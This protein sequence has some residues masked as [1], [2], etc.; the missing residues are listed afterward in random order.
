L[1]AGALE[2]GKITVNDIIIDANFRYLGH[3]MAALATLTALADA[4][5]NDLVRTLIEGKQVVVLPEVAALLNQTSSNTTAWCNEFDAYLNSLPAKTVAVVAPLGNEGVDLTELHV[6]QQTIVW[7]AE[8]PIV[9][10]NQIASMTIPVSG[11]YVAINGTNITRGN[12]YGNYDE[13]GTITWFVAPAAINETL[14]HFKL[15]ITIDGNTYTLNVTFEGAPL[16]VATGTIMFPKGTYGYVAIPVTAEYSNSVINVTFGGT[17]GTSIAAAYAAAAVALQLAD[18]N[19]VNFEALLNNLYSA[20][21][22][23]ES[24]YTGWG[25]ISMDRIWFS[26]VKRDAPLLSFPFDMPV[27][28]ITFPPALPA[29]GGSGTVAS[30]TTPSS[31]NAVSTTTTAI[32]TRTPVLQVK[33]PAPLAIALLPASLLRRVRRKRQKQ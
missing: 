18:P 15:N 7:P 21:P 14:N 25:A 1:I 22:G 17:E 9:L 33:V 12:V 24:P 2:S 8:C 29:S 32:V 16:P 4:A 26:T 30:T 31:N 28:G 27:Q 10:G 5:N 6:R 23:Y 13:N 20:Y 19:V 11:Y 3:E